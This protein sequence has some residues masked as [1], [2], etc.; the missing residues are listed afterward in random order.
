MKSRSTSTMHLGLLAG[1]ARIFR[2]SL[3]PR[4]ILR[5]ALMETVRLLRATSGSVV[6]INPETHLLEIEA[7]VGLGARGQRL[8]LHLGEGITGWVALHGVPLRLADVRLDARYVAARAGIRSELAIPL[9]QGGEAGP[10]VFGVLNV[11][12]V[13]A[14]AFSE[15]DEK[16]MLALAGQVSALIQNAWLYERARQR[17]GHLDGLLQLGRSIMTSETSREVLQQVATGACRLLNGSFCDVLL[18]D[19]GGEHLKWAATSE[20]PR[21]EPDETRVS[22]DDSQIGMAV[23]LRKPVTVDDIRRTDPLPFA[24]LLRSRKLV[25]MLAAPL[26]AGDRA[27]GAIALYTNFPHRFSNDEVQI[28]S[29]LASHTAL[30]LQRAHLSEKLVFTEEALRQSERLSAIG[31]LAAEVAHEIRNPLTVIKMLLHSLEREALPNDPRR[32]DFEV[33]SRKMEQMNRTVEGVLGLARSSEPVFE[34]Q[35]LHS[36]VED[37]VLLIRHK[38]DHQNIRL[39]LSLDRNLPGACI[40][41][42]QMEQALLN[43][44]L[45]ALHSMT[46]GG[47]LELRTGISSGASPRL[48]IEVRDSGTGMSSLQQQKLFQPFLTSRAAGTG[49]GMA[50]VNKIVRAHGGEVTVRSRLNQGT[51]VRI[52]LPA[53]RTPP[54]A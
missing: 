29:A 9:E 34:D 10:G 24:K 54:R 36:V 40:D 53:A 30:A 18:L 11:D 48:W 23:R 43:I 45:N 26:L 39:R 33:L 38:L 32:K 50:I 1:L 25:S 28:L 16:L 46:E 6:L 12:S 8:K 4:V 2:S 49:L 31:L 37:L 13:R 17:T 7:S 15:A 42:A 3:N 22:V 19:A 41:R 14:A 20:K 47:I 5:L 51:A 44:V 21:A 27:L 52:W 35:P